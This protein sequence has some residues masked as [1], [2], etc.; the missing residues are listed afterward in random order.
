MSTHPSRGTAPRMGGRPHSGPPL[1]IVAAAGRR[2]RGR[3]GVPYPELDGRDLEPSTGHFWI[4]SDTDPE[5][6]M[7][8]LRLLAEPGGGYRIGSRLHRPP[9]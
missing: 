4:G 5:V 8:C 9:G 7:A 6:A 2:V 1:L 3:A